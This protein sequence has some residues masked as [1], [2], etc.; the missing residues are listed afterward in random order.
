[1]KEVKVEFQSA[2]EHWIELTKDRIIKPEEKYRALHNYLALM[3][4]TYDLSITKDANQVILNHPKNKD[5]V[6][7]NLDKDYMI[8]SVSYYSNEVVD[9]ND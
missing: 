4:P 8:N 7:I 9:E 1:M 3:F 6:V 2:N 5:Y